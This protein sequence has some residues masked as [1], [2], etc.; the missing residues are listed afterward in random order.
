M[1]LPDRRLQALAVAVLERV[2]RFDQPAESVLSDVLRTSHLKPAP[3]QRERQA[4]GDMVFAIL[5]RLPVLK[6]LA[7]SGPT[8]AGS[9]H[10]RLA[11]LAWPAR[12]SEDAQD[13]PEPVQAWLAQADQ[14][15]ADPSAWA[16][17]LRHHLPPWLAKRLQLQLPE[18]FDVLAEALLQPAPLD[19]RVN[20][21]RTKR[22]P[23]QSHLEAD[24]FRCEPTPW[25]PWGLRLADKPSLKHHP[26][27]LDGSVE[28]QDEGSQVLAWL[29]D[30]RR[31]EMVCDF[32]A[33]AGGKTLALAAS[34]R[35]QGR[36]YAMDTS[37]HRLQ[38]LT[39]RLQRAGVSCVYP[40]ALAHERDDR[41]ERLSGKMD[42]VLVDAPCSGMGTLRRSPDLKWRHD[43]DDVGA[44]QAVQ[45]NILTSAARLVK[46]GGRLIYATCSL[47]REENEDVVA[48][49]GTTVSEFG[50][51]PMVDLLTSLGATEASHLCSENGSFLR[52]WPHRHATDG[53]FAAAWVRH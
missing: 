30:A 7:A 32:C 6:A 42:R 29:V 20:V 39:P 1:S 49:F 10:H 12:S 40:M 45:V 51:L 34:M 44:F 46:P 11:L 18:D 16:P 8:L 25:S 15:L 50:A 21:A 41:L 5:R 35:N 2:L 17:D 28:V 22:A 9:V 47:L 27:F 52:M 37:A 19:L 4:L 31:G 36:L 14:H 26:L 48:R 13:L 24:G 23:V 38:S 3:G 43:L 33:G 53:F